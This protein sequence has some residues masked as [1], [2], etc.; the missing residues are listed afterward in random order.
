MIDIRTQILTVAAAAAFMLSTFFNPAFAVEEPVTPALGWGQT[1]ENFIDELLSK[2]YSVP[3]EGEQEVS[4]EYDIDG[5]GQANIKIREDKNEL[6]VDIATAYI[7]P[8]SSAHIHHA[9]ARAAGVVV[10]NLPI[11][12]WEGKSSGCVEVEKGMLEKINQNP[13]DYYV[14][15]ITNTYPDGAIRGQLSL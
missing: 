1:F 7:D 15:I 10:V 3:L 5:T 4:D 14:N 6:C 13:Q 8:A 2:K 11:P 12:D 9:P